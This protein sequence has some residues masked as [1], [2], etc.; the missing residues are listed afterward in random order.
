MR[1]LLFV[2]LFCAAP[3]F[4]DAQT[5]TSSVTAPQP[6]E[7]ILFQSKVRQLTSYLKEN[8]GSA[9]NVLFKDVSKAMEGF[10]Q[11][12]ES[13]IDTANSSNKRKLKDK[14]D[15]QRQL[16]AQFQSFKPDLIRNR[17]SIETWADQ[18]VKTLY[19]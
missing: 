4:A 19:P 15:R 1:Y 17:S 3:I 12:T 8:N 18:F 9:A 13:A 11:A 16:M 7:R 6:D 10:I 2:L 14:L 5:D